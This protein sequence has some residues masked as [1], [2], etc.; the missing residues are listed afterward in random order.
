MLKALFDLLFVSKKSILYKFLCLKPNLTF[1]PRFARSENELMN[2]SLQ[3][4]KIQLNLYVTFTSLEVH[5]SSTLP[6]VV[7]GIS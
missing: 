3:A 5:T 7:V 2:E 1:V 4:C 6:V